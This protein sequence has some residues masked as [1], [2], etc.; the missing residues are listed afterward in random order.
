MRKIILCI[1]PKFYVNET[2]GYINGSILLEL[3]KVFFMNLKIT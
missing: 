1:N 2:S 3:I